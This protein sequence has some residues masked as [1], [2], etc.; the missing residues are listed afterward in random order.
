[1]PLTL[2]EGIEGTKLEP[3]VSG[4]TNF[5]PLDSFMSIE[6]W[7][8]RILLLKCGLVR[9]HGSDS[10]LR[11]KKG[12]WDDFKMEYGLDI[13]VVKSQVD[14]DW[15]WYMRIGDLDWARRIVDP[16]R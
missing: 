2:G 6:G 16:G 4:K 3:V 13:D 10:T 9:F 11:V 8:L 14:G 5:P 15:D 12:P 1:M 7:M